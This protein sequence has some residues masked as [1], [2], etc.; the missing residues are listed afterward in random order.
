M[1]NY[2]RSDIN[3]DNKIPY[4]LSHDV[5]G[6]NLKSFFREVG[7]NLPLVFKCIHR[8]FETDKNR[9]YKADLF[10]KLNSEETY[11]LDVLETHITLANYTYIDLMKDPKIVIQYLIY[12]FK[13]MDEPLCTYTCFPLFKNIC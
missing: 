9:Y 8:Y 13:C 12:V 11:H 6:K 4:V 5:I 7:S 1:L 10:D 2:A 3:I